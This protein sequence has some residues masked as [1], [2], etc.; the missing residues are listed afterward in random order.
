MVWLLPRPPFSGR[1]LREHRRSTDHPPLHPLRRILLPRFLFCEPSIQDREQD[2][3][4]HGRGEEAAD[5]DGRERSLDFGADPLRKRQ[6]Q[7]THQR[8]HHR[9]DNRPKPEDA[10]ADD[11]L[12]HL[13]A[14]IAQLID[15]GDQHDSVPNRQTEEFD[16][17]NGGQHARTRVSLRTALRQT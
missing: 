9:H 12:V 7:Q 5:D 10:T 6:R 1:A 17:A 13:R 8:R 16:T 3:R 4:E 2:Q 14:F 15:I 11:R